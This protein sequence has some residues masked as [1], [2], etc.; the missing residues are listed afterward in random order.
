MDYKP[1]ILYIELLM[2]FVTLNIVFQ[3]HATPSLFTGARAWTGGS[4]VNKVSAQN[5]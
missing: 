5:Q 1:Y 3:L 4:G 2:D